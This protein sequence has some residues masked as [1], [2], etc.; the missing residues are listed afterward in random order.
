MSILDRKCSKKFRES[1]TIIYNHVCCYIIPTRTAYLVAINKTCG[2]PLSW[3]RNIPFL[4]IDAVYIRCSF[5]FV[6][7]LSTPDSG[8]FWTL[9]RGPILSWT[10][11]IVVEQLRQLLWS[12]FSSHLTILSKRICFDALKKRRT[13]LRT[14]RFLMFG[15]RHIFIEFLPL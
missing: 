1:V 13:P 9:R 4:L 10:S 14:M 12:N 3:G 2:W 11:S 5:W 7:F 6:V 15:M 8:N